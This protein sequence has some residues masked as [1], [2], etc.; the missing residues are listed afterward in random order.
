MLICHEKDVWGSIGGNRCFDSS[1]AMAGSGDTLA[2]ED[3]LVRP[4]QSYIAAF[5][6]TPKLRE[7][8]WIDF[9]HQ[10]SAP[11]KNC[12]VKKKYRPS[13]IIMVD[14]I[15]VCEV[16]MTILVDHSGKLFSKEKC[17]I[18]DLIVNKEVSIVAWGG[19]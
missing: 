13:E 8:A 17:T 12:S 1:V 11:G 15:P 10:H 14:S 9:F 7:V 19:Q 18:K 4:C 3:S 6:E 2:T 16:G 5:G